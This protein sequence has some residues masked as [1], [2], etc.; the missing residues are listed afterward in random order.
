MHSP[1]LPSN[2]ARTKAVLN[3]ASTKTKSN[4]F[5]RINRSPKNW[6]MGSTR[7]MPAP[8]TKLAMSIHRPQRAPFP[9]TRRCRARR[10][11]AVPRE[12]SATRRRPS[13]FPQ[14]PAPALNARSRQD[15]KTPMKRISKTA[16]PRRRTRL[17]HRWMTASM[18][19]NCSSRTRRITKRCALVDLSS[20]HSLQTRK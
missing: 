19:S 2:R 3:V 11:K 4:R 12:R 10:S 5:R 7:S 18:S 1:N 9:L 16:R 20:T 8:S 6:R 13:P 17:R 14:N 15:Q